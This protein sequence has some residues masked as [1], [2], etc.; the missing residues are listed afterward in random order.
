M[1]TR[2]KSREILRED[3]RKRMLKRTEEG[4]K[5]RLRKSKAEAEGRR[6]WGK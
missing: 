2:G 3:K 4:K 5:T 1:E 6:R